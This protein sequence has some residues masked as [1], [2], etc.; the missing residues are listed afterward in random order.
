[1]RKPGQPVRDG[2]LEEGHRAGEGRAAG[3][4][5]RQ[6]V[7]QSAWRQQPNDEMEPAPTVPPSTGILIEKDVDVPMRDGARLKADVFRPDD[8]GKFPGD[9]QSRARTRR[10][11]SGC[12]RRQPGGKADTRDELGDRQLRNGGCRRAT[13]RCGSTA[14]AAASR[15]AS[16]S[17]GR[18]PRRSISTTRSNGRR[19]SPGATARSGSP[20]FPTSPSTSGSSPT[21]SRRR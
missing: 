14:A 17:R 2:A 6:S 19:R 12:R 4:T 13:P 18:S 15:P 21:C 10:T 7:A 20:A 11:S 5:E 9:P 3:V 1:M 16:A 8:G